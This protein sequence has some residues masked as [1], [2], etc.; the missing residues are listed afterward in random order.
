RGI[1]RSPAPSSARI[2]VTVSPYAWGSNRITICL[3]WNG[4]HRTGA[5]RRRYVWRIPGRSVEGARSLLHA[6]SGRRDVGRIAERLVHR[7]GMHAPGT[8]R[9]LA[10]SAHGKDDARPL[11]LVKLEGP[12][13]PGTAGNRGAPGFRTLPAPH[14]LCAHGDT[15]AMDA[16]AAGAW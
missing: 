1:M 5:F 14:S 3:T 9:H 12:L 11:A 15:G 6:G 2:F 16:G 7:R 13:G 10:R 4:D 8:H